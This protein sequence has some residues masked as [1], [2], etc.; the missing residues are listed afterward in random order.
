VGAPPRAR[1]APDSPPFIV[2]GGNINYHPG[3]K[4]RGI[5]FPTT[6]GPWQ[7]EPP[8]RDPAP[9]AQTGEKARSGGADN[10]RFEA[11]RGSRRSP[12]ANG[13]DPKVDPTLTGAWSFRG[14][15]LAPSVVAVGRRSCERIPRALSPAL[16]PASG[17]VGG[18]GSGCSGPKPQL[19]VP[20]PAGGSET[21]FPWWPP[22]SGSARSGRNLRVCFLGERPENRP[23]AALLRVPLKRPAC[24]GP[25]SSSIR[26]RRPRGQLPPSRLG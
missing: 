14:R 22:A 1:L 18:F 8:I 2:G 21:D 6:V 26:S 15:H 5:G 20:A 9:G 12:H 23:M 16:A 13:A 7:A 17:S 24:V 10:A 25:K 3:S 4:A 11:G 19:A